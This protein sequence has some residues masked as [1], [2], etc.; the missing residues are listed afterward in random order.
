[1]VGYNNQKELIEKKIAFKVNSMWPAIYRDEGAELV[2]LVKDYYE[3]L[4]TEYN[5]SHYN[6][7]RMYEYRDISTTLASMIIHFQKA[8]LADLPLLDDTTVRIVIKNI[9]DLYR[10]KGTRGG[11]VVFFRLFYQEYAEVV[12]PSKYM[13]KPSDSTWK[14]GTYLEMFPNDNVFVSN[15]GLSYTYENLL[16]R[17]I[18]GSVSGAKAVVDKI[19]FIIKNKTIYAVIYLNNVKGQFQ[20][21]DDILARI[22]GEDV[23]FGKIGGSLNAIQ[24]IDEAYGGTTGNKVGDVYNVRSS[25]GSGG[26]VLVTDV[27]AQQT[28]IIKYE[29]TDGGFGYTIEGTRLIVSNQVIVFDNPNFIFEPDLRI[30]QPSTSALATVIGQNSVVAGVKLDIG[31]AEFEDSSF[32]QTVQATD[33]LKSVKLIP[34]SETALYNSTYTIIEGMQRAA[35][36]Q[37]PELTNFTPI[38]GTR[39]LGDVNN[40]SFVNQLDVD[41]ITAYFDGTLTDEA[42]IEWIERD[43]KIR[44]TQ[45]PLYD[46]YPA[47]KV[48]FNAVS[49]KNDSSPGPLYPDTLNTA[50]VKVES[51]SNIENISLITDLISDFLS[52]PLNSSNY[53]T[54]PPAIQAMSGTADPVTLA[55]P[56]NEAFDLTP[57]NI[58]VIDA[59]ENVN[60]GSDYVNDVFALVQDSTMIPFA[61]YEQIII[62]SNITAAFSVG[63][64]ITQET[65]GVVGKI[66]GVNSG[67]K[68]IKVTPYAYYGFNST[69]DILFRG[70]NYPILASER[71]YTSKVIGANADMNAKTIFEDGRIAGVKVINSGFA[72]PDGEVIFIVDDNNN[73]QARGTTQAVTE[74]ITEGFWGQLNSHVNGYTSTVAENGADVYYEGQMRIQD[75]DFYQE[76]SYDIKSSV[77]QERY[78]GSLNKNVHLAGTKQFGSFLYQ[79]KQNSGIAQR[80]YHNVK[81]DYLLGGIDVV[82]PGQDTSGQGGTITMD[83]T[84]YTADSTI[85]R[86]DLVR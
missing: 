59:F 68:F 62:L 5:Q 53:N 78:R 46:A 56:L 54:V 71:D 13:F 14:T 82:G 80:F 41:N 84:G 77:S 73:I 20:K 7:R 37:Q 65:S 11:I 25:Y 57:F 12:Y 3:F 16:S 31:S 72:Y 70:N 76:Y 49:A 50:D 69:N 4:E 44:L 86:A 8:F 34:A 52:V 51:L 6:N 60:P 79:K 55:T 45:N 15:S 24:P 61:R 10:R 26:K 63:D 39:Q 38:V 33:P 47:Y 35:N 27:S 9:M 17:N 2:Q 43:F 32:I 23:S 67:E 81:N 21:F 28:G 74:G 19:N 48:Y 40:D 18:K 85:L 64:I 22:A 30:E 75:S 29:L 42:T 83:T 36:G 66:T 1:M 58:G